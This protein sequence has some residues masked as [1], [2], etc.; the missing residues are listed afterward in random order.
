MKTFTTIKI[1]IPQRKE[2]FETM[3]QYSFSAQKVIDFGWNIQTNNK[4]ELHDLTYYK[5]RKETQL[6]AQLV[7]SSRD[8]A[9]EVL[10]AS[11]FKHSKPVMKNFLTIRYDA[12]SFSLKH[13]KDS[14]YLSLSTIEGR[15]KIPI[16]IPEYYWKYLDWKVC[17][18]DL[19]KRKKGLFL[20]I[21]MSRN[22]PTPKISKGFLGVDVGINNIAVTSNRRFFN[23]KQIKRKKLMFKR[24]R[25]KLQSKGTRSSRRLLKKISGRENRWMTWINH[26][27]SKQIVD[28]EEGTI[29]MENI[30]GI[31]KQRKGRRLNYW[32][33][34]WSYFQLQSF[35]EYKAIS[36]GKRF[37][38]VSP[39]MTSQTC[40]RCGQVGSRS[41]SFFKCPHC[42]YTLNADLNASFNLAKHN[43]MSDCV[44]AAV[45][46]PHIQVY[47]HKGFSQAI[48]CEIMD[49]S[50]QI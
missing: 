23:A 13:T 32:L 50:H 30:K 37:T 14:Y 5:I 7:C 26:N 29:V 31:R 41:K 27:I 43:S 38:K 11:K 3:K 47:E 4:R 20:N 9:V 2:L 48:A 28:C 45:T 49:K 18:A 40:S 46:Q 10:K 39:Y 8:K 15:I 35:V 1:K 44:S 24:L 21:A 22:L 33:S 34:N 19:I 17:S 42:G 12:R 25:A 6:P 16:E 36:K